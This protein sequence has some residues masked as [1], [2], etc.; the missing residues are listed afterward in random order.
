M[1]PVS[2]LPHALGTDQFLAAL[3]DSSNDAIIGTTPEGIVVSW[4]AGAERLCGYSATEMIGREISVLFPLDRLDEFSHLRDRAL[5]GET[6]QVRQAERLRK[7][8]TLVP[9]SV[10]ISP[11]IGPGGEV[12]GISSIAR[13]MTHQVEAMEALRLSERSTA[14]ALSVLE[15]LQETAPVGFGF[16]DDQFRVVRLNEMLASINGSSAKNVIG[17]TVQDVV[18]TIWPQIEA[19]FRRV[20]ESG[21]S[22][23]NLEVSG[24]I[25]RE[26][27]Q[28]HHWLASYFPVRT[29]G[30]I[31]G[32]GIVVVD[33]TERKKAY[34]AQRALTRAAVD[35][36]AATVEARDP[37]TAGH[38]NRVATIASFVANDLGL[39]YETIDGIDLAARI[40]DIGKISIPAEILARP[41]KLSAPEWAIIKTHPR[42][43]ADIIRG[44]EFPW[45]VA[46]TI[47]QH[48]ERLDG[49][50][51]PDGLSGDAICLGARI[52]AVADVLEAMSSHR[53]YRPTLGIE[54][55]LEEIERG[56]GTL[57]DSSVVDACLHLFR[58]GVLSLAKLRPGTP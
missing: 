22:V 34:E 14:E 29:E 44:I 37:Y 31:I 52:V 8:G 57:F 3:V 26:P 53:P 19:V 24:E 11:V 28:R 21:E 10:T 27:G 39:H 1:N 4:N 15:S 58:D 16:I 56:S 55:A 49:S 18:P 54:A 48:H 9:T 42:V 12:I 40:H 7:D 51:Y 25:A 23:S 33:V 50:G 43:G 36:M 20:M 45:P 47:E 30:E 38:Q 46:E 6:I 13:D 2:L 5:Q 41:G 32:L 17:R 35:A